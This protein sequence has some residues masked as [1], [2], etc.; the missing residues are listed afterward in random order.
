MRFGLLGPLLVEEAGTRIP[1]R[2]ARQRVLLA[3]LLLRANTVVPADELAE[4]IWDGQPPRGARGALQNHVMR[5]RKSLGDK[6]GARLRTQPPG[7]LF[8][9]I[10]GELDVHR[11][12]TMSDAGRAAARAYDWAAASTLM[13]DALALWRG[14]ALVDV[15]SEVLRRDE[16]GRLA[17]LQIQAVEARV[18]ADLQLDRYDEVI[19]ELHRM[20]AEHPLR[21]RLRGQLMR[22]LNLSGRQAEALAIYPR[23]RDELVEELGVDPGPELQQL[24][25]RILRSAPAPTEPPPAPDHPVVR[26]RAAELATLEKAADAARDGRP[27][28]LCVE[29]PSGIGK[30]TLLRE[31]STIESERGVTVLRAT[32]AE[33][34]QDW[35][36]ATVRQLLHPVLT[37]SEAERELLFVGQAAL[38]LRVLA[39]DVPAPAAAAQPVPSALLLHALFWLLVNLTERGPVIL[40][41]DDLDRIDPPSLRWLAYLSRR[42]SGLPVLIVLARRCGEGEPDPALHELLSRDCGRLA[43]GPL[44]RTAVARMVRARLGAAA[45]DRF[46]ESCREASSGNPL[47][48]AEL[49]RTIAESGLRPVG[50]NID[51]VHE[52][53][54]QA[55]TRG[56][57]DRLSREPERP[58][59][60]ARTLAVLDEDVDRATLAD[61]TELTDFDLANQLRRLEL[62]GVLGT[63]DP[64]RFRHRLVRPAV[65]ST[66][67]AA[68][69][70]AAHVRAA[71]VRYDGG[72]PSEV[73]AGHLMHSDLIDD[74]WPAEVLQ[75]AAQ[76][77]RGRGAPDVAVLFLRR[78]LR[79]PLDKAARTQVLVALGSDLLFHNPAGAARHLRE[80]MALMLNAEQRGRTAGLLANALL[81]ARRG[82]EAV[83]VLEEAVAELGAAATGPPGPRREL[84]L[85]LQAQLIQ[86]AYENVSTIPVVR[87]VLHD[88]AEAPPRGDTPGERALL[89]ALSLDGA[90]GNLSAAQTSELLG[91]ALHGGL[92]LHGPAGVLFALA[93]I[94][95][96]AADR[97]P[98]ASG[99]FREIGEQ[100]IHSGSPYL[101]IL[102]RFGT[103]TIASIRGDVLPSLDIAQ[104][105]L[106]LMPLELGYSALP[107]V[108]LAVNAHIELGD[109]AAAEAIVRRHGATHA[110][111]AAWDRGR[112]LLMRGRLRVAAGDVAG[113]LAA[114][115][116]CGSTQNA[117]GIAS[118]AIAAWRSQAA[119][120][121]AALGQAGA[122]RELAAEELELARR[123]GTPR[124]IGV[125]MRALG[126]VT[127][128][129]AGLALLTDAVT[130]LQRSPSRLEEARGRYELGRFQLSSGQPAAGIGNLRTAADLAR[131][132]GARGLLAGVRQ[133]LALAGTTPGAALTDRPA[134][135]LDPVGRHLAGLAAGGLSDAEIAQLLFTTPRTVHN[136]LAAVGKQ[137]GVDRSGLVSA[138][139]TPVSGD[140]CAPA[141]AGD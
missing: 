9:V 61:V 79:E 20:I 41:V 37:R 95:L 84:A 112:F 49:L 109:V 51:Q 53:G 56:I 111:D 26:D 63:V 117:A 104:T 19:P 78:A 60:V 130:E 91:R 57:V 92:H 113:G 102:S 48:L 50:D 131:R 118:P 8:E 125:S 97:L 89:A 47:F 16:G 115:L 129:E 108:A 80:A 139:V 100:A 6:V 42:L 126:V 29:G 134:D 124:S 76:L 27:S 12:V 14:A 45:D 110:P 22:A 35:A 136:R 13:R 122:A 87:K 71:R 46:C 70:T 17:E 39:Y 33:S 90:A 119:L 15:P 3:S 120:A 85:L 135:R 4:L 106:E 72:A 11:F 74:R 36:F 58:R 127:G 101:S 24:H 59:L 38:A 133:S 67:T 5:L 107:F 121:Y 99:W 88:L 65:L 137:L 103:S 30:S 123:W 116:E 132:C 52:Y 77:A 138:Q 18:D 96:L 28:L 105:V 21:E 31:W 64:P 54:A 62:L 128:G 44:G 68:E 73:V 75:D 83:A 69:L 86:V 34:E 81:M 32:C 94:G 25:Q 140:G 2:A 23:F 10:D 82:P 1:V 40:V 93:A 55:L 98:E 7:Y 114:L 141:P 43:V 66:M